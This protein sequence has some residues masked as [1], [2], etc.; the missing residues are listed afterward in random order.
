M[1][2]HTH[3]HCPAWSLAG[4]AL[5]LLP[6][7]WAVLSPLRAAADTEPLQFQ[8]VYDLLKANL[9]GTTEPELNRA[10]VR[11]LLEQLAGKVTVVGETSRAGSAPSQPA[12][13]TASIFDGKFGY[14]RLS[15][16]TPDT[17]REFGAALEGL[18]GTNSLKGLVLDVR[19]A[20]GQEYEAAVALAD[21]FLAG[22]QP[23]VDWGEGWKKSKGRNDAIA[24]P[25]AILVNRQTSGAAEV[26]AGILRYRDVGLLIG[27]NTAGQA[28]MAKEFTLKTGQRLRVA[29]APV[30]VADGQELPFTGIKPDIEVEVNADD[31]LAWYDDAF[32]SIK[33]SRSGS[34]ST[35]DTASA[36]TNRPARGRI[37]EAYLVRMSR[38]GQNPEREPAAVPA[39]PRSGDVPPLVN[40]PVLGRALDL[41]KGLAVVQASRPL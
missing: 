18:R 27:T 32:K 10:A 24:L 33:A 11:G 5:V 41:L 30:K 19:F 20:G 21:R 3:R 15:R 38:E 35:N 26:L 16:L 40:D 2:L 17:D 34:V 39:P 7:G 12:P 1:H 28:S 4:L 36:G 13:V 22:D 6:A 29:I 9:A 14:V 31:E 8:E 23:L 25:L 37:N